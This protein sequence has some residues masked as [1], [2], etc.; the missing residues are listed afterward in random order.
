MQT[1]TEEVSPEIAGSYEYQVIQSAIDELS[2]VLITVQEGLDLEFIEARALSRILD[3]QILLLKN[4]TSCEVISIDQVRLV[5]MESQVCLLSLRKKSDIVKTLS[6]Y[7]HDRIQQMKLLRR[8]R[9]EIIKKL[10][11]CEVIELKRNK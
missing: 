3:N 7:L 10:T 1:P 6:K 5:R 9:E 11:P 8:K 4:L 2:K